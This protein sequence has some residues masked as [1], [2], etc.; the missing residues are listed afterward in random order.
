VDY[1]DVL[2]INILLF[3]IPN[4]TLKLGFGIFFEI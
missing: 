3:K 2:K 1:D 4:P